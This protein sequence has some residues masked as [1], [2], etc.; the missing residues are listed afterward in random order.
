MLSK[1]ADILD[2]LY[3]RHNQR[4]WVHPDPLE[5]LYGYADAA[6]REIV[7]LL[8]SCLAY[9]RVT[10]ILRSVENVLKRLGPNPAEFL[11]GASSKQLSILFAD[12]RHRFSGGEEFSGLLAGAGKILRRYGSLQACFREGLRESHENVLPALE[13]FTRKLR[14]A[15]GQNLGHLLPD[16]SAGSACKRLNLLLRW[17]VRRD[18]VDPGGWTDVP[19]R[20]LIVPLDTHMHRLSLEMGATRRRQADLR[21]A[22]EITRAFAS[23]HPHDPVR[24]DFSL[25]RLGIHPR[26][27]MSAFLRLCRTRK[28]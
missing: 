16:V 8:A 20:M 28:G 4:E 9:G 1:Y 23:L 3:L 24:Y 22:V 25:T 18:D 27:D 12:F 15:A 7:A 5:Y 10:Q 17:L 6:D 11:R 19:A 26:A 13:A 14:D 2:E 21:T